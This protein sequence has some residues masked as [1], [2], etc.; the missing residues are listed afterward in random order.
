[1]KIKVVVTQ[2]HIDYGKAKDCKKCPVALALRDAGLFEPSIGYETCYAGIGR[3][4]YHFP[5]WVGDKIAT[6]DDE[7]IMAP[8]EFE[9]EKARP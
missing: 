3:E 7:Y 6:F 1:M 9:I 8:F 2:H 4:E 5:Q